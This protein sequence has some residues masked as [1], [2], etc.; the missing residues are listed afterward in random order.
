VD[1][2]MWTPLCHVGGKTP[3]KPPRGVSRT[4]L[5]VRGYRIPGFVV[6]G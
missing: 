1:S 3:R 6:E 4:V 5:I 2:D